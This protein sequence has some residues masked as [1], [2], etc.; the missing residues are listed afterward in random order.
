MSSSGWARLTSIPQGI[1]FSSSYDPGL[2]AAMRAEIPPHAKKWSPSDKTWIIDQA[3]ADKVAKLCEIYLGVRPAVPTVSGSAEKELRQ[4]K[5]LYVGQVKERGNGENIA[6]GLISDKGREDWGVIFPEAVLRKWFLDDSKLDTVQTLY[7]VLMV[8]HDAP[9]DVI[10]KSFWR[11][12]HQWHPDVCKEQDAAAQ[13]KKINRAYE[14]LSDV[15]KR[16][17]Y[18]LGLALESN[19]RNA[20]RLEERYQSLYTAYRPPLRCGMIL[21]EGVM[22]VGRFVITEIHNWDDIV[23]NGKTMVSSYAKDDKGELKLVINWR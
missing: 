23:K 2:V 3:W 6:Q 12:A 18:N 20:A 19:A 9:E 22:K 14:V 21:A 5:L 7:A 16:R 15:S 4:I 17:K 10:K 11:L 13:F 1:R 8:G